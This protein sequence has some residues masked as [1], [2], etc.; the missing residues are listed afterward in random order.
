MVVSHCLVATSKSQK[1][2]TRFRTVSPV[3][4]HRAIIGKC[5]QAVFSKV[6]GRT[7]FYPKRISN[8]SW[9]WRETRWQGQVDLEAEVKFAKDG[10]NPSASVLLLDSRS[11][12]QGSE[13]RAIVN[14]GNGRMEEAARTGSGPHEG[15]QS[16]SACA[17]ESGDAL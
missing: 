13:S 6:T 14:I 17:R 16:P 5:G 15:D 9:V 8:Q 4:F 7:V 3:G 10:G 11:I 12:N 1:P 2:T